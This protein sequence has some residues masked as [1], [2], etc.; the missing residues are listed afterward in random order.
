MNKRKKEET[1]PGAQLPS[2]FKLG[3]AFP[4]FTS[5]LV[6]SASVRPVQTWQGLLSPH[7]PRPVLTRK[8]SHLE[9]SCLLRSATK[10][11]PGLPAW[12]STAPLLALSLLP[13]HS[14]PVLMVWKPVW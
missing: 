1:N 6:D 3:A 4:C 13:Q 2:H 8:A 10:A 7:A 14:H 12:L 11:F 9:S 5:M